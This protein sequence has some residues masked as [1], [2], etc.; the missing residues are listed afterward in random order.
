[1]NQNTT[2][3]TGGRSHTE[4]QPSTRLN[5]H[6]LEGSGTIRD[7]SVQASTAGTL[8]TVAPL[9]ADLI[10]LQ[11]PSLVKPIGPQ[12][13]CQA[14]ALRKKYFANKY[15]AEEDTLAHLH[16]TVGYI[17]LVLQYIHAVSHSTSTI[18]A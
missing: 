6:G 10:M 7:P 2:H 17:C 18:H 16:D 1:M 4:S 3:N 8:L 9:I 14:L 15:E 11:A 5:F 12:L 13:S